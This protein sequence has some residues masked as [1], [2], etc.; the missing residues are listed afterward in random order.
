MHAANPAL[1]IEHAT[2]DIVVLLIITGERF[3]ALHTSDFCLTSPFGSGY[4]TTALE[5]HANRLLA[6]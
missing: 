4:R 2:V 5:K 6:G 3:R 1:A